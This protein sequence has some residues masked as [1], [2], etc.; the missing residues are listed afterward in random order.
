[1]V[2]YKALNTIRES[3][4]SNTCHGIRNR[5]WGEAA[6]ISKSPISNTCHRIRNRD[7]GEA[8]TDIESRFSNTCYGI[9]WIIISNRFGNN[10][11]T[12]IF[13]VARRYCGGCSRNVIVNTIYLNIIGGCW[14]WENNAEDERCQAYCKSFFHNNLPDTYFS[15]EVGCWQWLSPLC[16]PRGTCLTA[17]EAVNVIYYSL[18]SIFNILISIS[19][20]R[21][22]MVPSYWGKRGRGRG[23]W[24]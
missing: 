2:N 10:Y 3:I 9:F 21:M 16:P 20:P 12:W 1:M 5:D 19:L 6:A 22:T 13:I 24:W 14:D 7:W 8:A 18:F 15:H 23:H 17:A 11:V 4:T